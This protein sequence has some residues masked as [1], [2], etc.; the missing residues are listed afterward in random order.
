MIKAIK[1]IVDTMGHYSRPDVVRVMLRGEDGWR[2]AGQ[3]Y[4][5][6]PT[7]SIPRPAL[8]RAADNRE[9]AYDQVARIADDAKLMIER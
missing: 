3:P 7:A 9:V 8:E 6:G 2:Q 4:L 1:A 5:S